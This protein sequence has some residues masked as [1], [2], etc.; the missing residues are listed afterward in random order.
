MVTEGTT[1]ARDNLN[2]DEVIE[3]V[4][5][6]VFFFSEADSDS[7]QGVYSEDSLAVEMGADNIYF[8]TSIA[9]ERRGR[10]L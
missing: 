8:G 4:F 1:R 6:F 3:G 5:V 10:G 9:Q 2:V 7:L